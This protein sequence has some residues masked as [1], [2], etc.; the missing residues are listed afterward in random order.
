LVI[1]QR[2]GA[3]LDHGQVFV[4][5]ENGGVEAEPMVGGEA[6]DGA[7]EGK[8]EDFVTEWEGGPAAQHGLKIR[9]GF[10]EIVEECGEAEDGEEAGELGNFGKAGMA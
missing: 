1:F 8:G 9:V 10:A 7:G 2:E 6:R 5:G 3:R 4:M